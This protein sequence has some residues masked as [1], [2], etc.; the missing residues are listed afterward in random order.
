MPAFSDVLSKQ[1]SKPVPKPIEGPNP[2][3]QAKAAAAAKAA[4]VVKPA[5][6]LISQA[7]GKTTAAPKPQPV[8]LSTAAPAAAPAAGPK[9]QKA[10]EWAKSMLG[11]QDWNNLCERFV[12]EAYGTRGIYPTAKD[13]GNAIVT[14]K[15]RSSLDSAPPGALLYFAADETNDWA[16]HAAIYLGKGQ[17]ISARP[18]GVKIESMDT[19]YNKERYIGWGDAPSRF[20]GLEGPA[21]APAAPP[22][23]I[24]GAGRPA[25]A[26][27]ASMPP[28]IPGR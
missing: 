24:Q 8:T 13:A 12:E 21:P 18:N 20:P 2:A 16:G 26:L 4:A 17:M 14:H 6:T 19:P 7:A 11:R 28:R 5:G 27:S 10:V 1:L 3:A 15:G 9:A 23:A 22:A 25:P